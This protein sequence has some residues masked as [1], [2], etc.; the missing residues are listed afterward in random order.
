MKGEKGEKG[1]ANSY[2]CEKRYKKEKTKI[3]T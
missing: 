1:D 3:N 2:Q